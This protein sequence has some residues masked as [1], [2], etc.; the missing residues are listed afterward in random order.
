MK[1]IQQYN[2]CL[3]KSPNILQI[4]DVYE[5]SKELFLVLE[6]VEG[7]ELFDYLVKKGRLTENEALY[8]FQQIIRGVEYCHRYMIW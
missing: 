7:G 5:A 1:L 8:F 4:Y 3:T 2:F 6:Q